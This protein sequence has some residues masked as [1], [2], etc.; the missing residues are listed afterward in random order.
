MK[1][2]RIYNII[3]RSDFG[4]Y[5]D[6]RYYLSDESFTE[7][8]NNLL[9]RLSQLVLIN[10]NIIIDKMMLAKEIN[11][12]CFHCKNQYGCC[13]GSPHNMNIKQKRVFNKYA[14]KI[15]DL[16]RVNDSERYRTL[17]SNSGWISKGGHINEYKKCC[18]FVIY[19]DGITKCAIHK[20]ANDNDINIYDIC[21][22]SCL[23]FPMDII[24]L[25]DNNGGC[26]YYVTSIADYE[27]WS[28]FGRWGN[29][30]EC[31]EEFSVQ[32]IYKKQHGKTEFKL[33]DYKPVW[34]I[35]RDLLIYIFGNDVY[36]Q[37]CK[38]MEA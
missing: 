26:I 35:N 30:E 18:S 5:Y 16:I 10:D 6:I 15:V 36:K 31:N 37:I 9:S 7:L 24:E 20:F 33:K 2:K 22:L 4:K 25:R 19:K 28:K 13:D 38:I 12:D 8:C 32:C 1:N 21:P 34:K 14:D 23:M 17:L 3:K 27:F 11:L 29:Y